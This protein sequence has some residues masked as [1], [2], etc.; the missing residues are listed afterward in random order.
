M[1]KELA[2]RSHVSPPPASEL[3]TLA[4][5]PA[6]ASML[7]ER[8]VLRTIDPERDAEAL[9]GATHGSVER[10][11][12]WQFVLPGP[13]ADQASMVRWLESCAP[14]DDPH[15]FTVV[16]R[17]QG[18]AVGIVAFTNI[19][20]DMRVIEVG[21]I[22]YVLDAQRTHIN[23][24]AL[25]LLLRCAF[26]TL[27]YRRVEWKCDDQNVRS[28]AAA[29]RLGFSFEGVFRQHMIMRGRNRDTAWF[30]ML[31][32]DWPAIRRGFEH[33]LGRHGD[34]DDEGASGTRDGADRRA[35]LSALIA[36]SRS[37]PA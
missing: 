26:D 10:E 14:V 29:Q 31:D 2:K 35:S 12:V 15:R 27:G 24:E 18:R 8:V 34:T 13:F 3:A 36:E 37:Q 23:T 30:A 9:Y 1:T 21:H 6:R 28:R 17:S 5:L 7:G 4:R 32:G 11:A 22:W 19:R 20:P 16:D 33:F 25:Y